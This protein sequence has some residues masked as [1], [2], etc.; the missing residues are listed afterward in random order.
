MEISYSV[1]KKQCYFWGKHLNEWGKKRRA[2]RGSEL[3]E[4]TVNWESGDTLRGSCQNDDESWRVG[5]LPVDW[6]IERLQKGKQPIW[7]ISIFTTAVF[8]L[9]GSKDQVVRSGIVHCVLGDGVLLLYLTMKKLS[10][11]I[12]LPC[13]PP[14]SPFPV[15][16]LLFSPLLSCLLL[17]SFP[18]SFPC[19]SSYRT[20]KWKQYGKGLRI[21][22]LSTG[23]KLVCLW[24]IWDTKFIIISVRILSPNSTV[25][26][27]SR[28]QEVNYT[29]ASKRIKTDTKQRYTYLLIPR[30]QD[31]K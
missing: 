28:K 6:S 18:I 30:N 14:C 25:L 31:I 2:A 12:H 21:E 1:W 24:K 20:K 16:S 19:S 9:E 22:K 17:F 7:G 5:F 13:P 23:P 11:S 8:V 15:P 26:W 10:P 27:I 29:K 3:E 4:V